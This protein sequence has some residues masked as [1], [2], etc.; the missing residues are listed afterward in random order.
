MTNEEFNNNLKKANG[1]LSFLKEVN[2]KKDEITKKGIDGNEIISCLSKLSDEIAKK[3]TSLSLFIHKAYFDDFVS[4]RAITINPFDD[5]VMADVEGKDTADYIEVRCDFWGPCCPSKYF[6]STL[7]IVVVDFEAYSLEGEYNKF[8]NG[9]KN[10]FGGHKQAKD[11]PSY[12]SLEA[13][14]H[15]IAVDFCNRLL[16]KEDVPEDKTNTMTDHLC[17]LEHNFFPA[18]ALMGNKSSNRSLIDKLAKLFAE[19]HRELL[20]FYEPRIV[21]GNRDCMGYLCSYNGLFNVA[22]LDGVKDLEGESSD[23]LL[24]S[25]PDASIIGHKVICSWYNHALGGKGASAILDENGTLWIGYVLSTSR[26]EDQW[27]EEDQNVLA[28]WI[29]RIRLSINSNTH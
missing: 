22:L 1:I 5:R 17:I 27:T 26:R 19:I 14:T 21:L 15:T 6:E 20:I 7:K 10:Y 3:M 4:G 12:D 16:H 24:K 25:Y 28:S 2:K 13:P 18:L 9:I 11:F 29:N 23:H 8:K